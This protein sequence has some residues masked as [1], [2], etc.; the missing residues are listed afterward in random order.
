[1]SGTQSDVDKERSCEEKVKENT[2]ELHS[3]LLT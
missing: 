3:S 1:M 2:P